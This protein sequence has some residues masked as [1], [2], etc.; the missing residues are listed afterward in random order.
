MNIVRRFD[1]TLLSRILV[2][3]I[4]AHFMAVVPSYD[5][6]SPPMVM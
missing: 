2:V 4:L 5:I 3:M 1:T 6:L